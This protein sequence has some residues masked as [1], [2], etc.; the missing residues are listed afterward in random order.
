MD[1]AIAIDDVLDL[2]TKRKEFP[3]PPSQFLI[4]GAGNRGREIRETLRRHGYEVSAFVDQNGTP[5]A[6]C[7]G[8]RCFAPSDAEPRRIS[9]EGVPM[10]VAIWRHDIDLGSVVE[11]LQATGYRRLFTVYDV[12]QRFP[13]EF[14]APFWLAPVGRLLASRE[15]I[16]KAF[17]LLDDRKSKDIFL[18]CLRLR[19][20]GDVDTLRSPDRTGQYFPA[21][22][23]NIPKDLRM[24]DCGAFTGDTYR[25]I[26]ESGAIFESYVALEPD[27]QNFKMLSGFFREAAVEH[28]VTLLPCGAWSTSEA[29]RFNAGSGDGSHIDSAGSHFIQAVALDE[30]LPTYRPNFIKMDIEGA[31]PEAISGSNDLIVRN[32]PYMAVA[33]YHRPDHLWGLLLQINALDLGYRFRIRYHWFTGFEVDLYALPED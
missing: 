30:A 5:D 8:L 21:D 11:T 32:R 23:W 3:D 17:G 4:Y 29:L 15:S 19:A 28:P 12:Y 13:E 2:A 10:I 18:E 24:I 31:E 33:S 16:H 20:T 22:V 9:A 1:D 25:T 6:T 26:R 14:S 27:P 7:H